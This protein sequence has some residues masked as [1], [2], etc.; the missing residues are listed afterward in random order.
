LAK[1]AISPSCSIH[2]NAKGNLKP[3]FLINDIWV[4]LVKIEN[5]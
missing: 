1:H 2:G 4:E 5:M 3:L